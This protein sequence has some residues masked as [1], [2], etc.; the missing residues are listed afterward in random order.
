MASLVSLLLVAIVAQADSPRLEVQ[1]GHNAWIHG[2]AFS[3][4]G[5]L[6]ASASADES[7]RIWEVE[8]GRK[9]R[10]FYGH[11]KSVGDV[12]FHPRGKILVSI[13]LGDGVKLWDVDQGV[14]LVRW[15]DPSRGGWCLALN[16]AGTVI[17]REG[18]VGNLELLDFDTGKILRTLRGHQ[19]GIRSAA[20]DP[21]GTLLASGG[22]DGVLRVWDHDQGKELH[23]LRTQKAE[24]GIKTVAFSPDGLTLA[25]GDAGGNTHLWDTTTWQE[26]L[27]LHGGEAIAF[28]RDGRM[29]VG[30]A[31]TVVQIFDASDGRRLQLLRGHKEDINSVAVSPDDRWIASASDDRTVRIWERKSG[32]FV[33][34]LS[35]ESDLPYRAVFRRDGRAIAAGYSESIVALWDLASGR[36]ARVF[37]PRSTS[38]IDLAYSPD[39]KIV[40]VVDLLQQHLDLWDAETGQRLRNLGGRFNRFKAVAFRPD[41]RMMAASGR[42]DVGFTTDV[43][44]YD[45]ETGREIRIFRGHEVDVEA[46]AFRPDG[47]LLA[48][49]DGDGIVKLWDV[50]TGKEIRAVAGHRDDIRSIAFGPDGKTFFTTISDDSIIAWETDSGNRVHRFPMKGINCGALSPDGRVLAGGGDGAIT[51]WDVPGRRELHTYHVPGE[52]YS[53]SFPPDGATLLSAGLDGLIRLWNAR[54]PNFRE[55]ASLITFSDGTWAVTDPEGRFDASNGG[56]SSGL[57]WVVGREPIALN[58][59]KERYY[60]PGLLGK[61]SGFVKEPPRDVRGFRDVRLYPVVAFEPPAPSDTRMTLRLTDRGGGI[62]KV[63]VFVNDKELLADARGPRPDPEAHEARLAVDLAGAPV[64]R[65]APNRIRVVAWNA[66]GYLASR[67]LEAIWTPAGPSEA[68]TPELFAI[69]GGVSTYAAPALALRF[70]A[71]DADDFA[72]ALELGARRLLG[73]E[74]VHFT[75]LSTSD[76]PRAIVPTKDHF[77]EAFSAARRAR[78][79]DILLVYLAGHGVSLQRG[80]DL[81]CYLTQEARTTDSALLASD[82]S[83]LERYTVTSE[84]LV[85]WIKAIPALKQV[86]MLDTCAAGAAVARLTEL[87]EIS[88][89]QIR[90]MERLKDRTGFHILMGCASDRVSFEASQYGQGLLTYAL[91]Q[92][93]R[94]SALRDDEYVDV[95]RLFQF[96][97]DR[98]PELARGIGGV[99]KPLIAAPRG[100]SF[101]VGRLTLSDK[102]AI[103]LALARP[104]LLRPLL[105]NPDENDDNL[106]LAPMLKKRLNEAS[107][108]L[109]RGPM[110]RRAAIFVDADELPGAIRPT[111][112]YRVNG[113]KV[114]VHLLLKRDREKLGELDVEGTV[115]DTENLVE[116]TAAAIFDSLERNGR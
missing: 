24:A 74:R 40:A 51:L 112:S 34:V 9:L 89:D 2:I 46:L 71:K 13:G 49:G 110:D 21:R 3:P 39:G 88:G 64:I 98:V 86:M 19:G 7:I 116:K 41:G 20:F 92:G 23:A 10:T 90:A 15:H 50:E 68:D 44:L 97:A 59:L 87:R 48:T 75:L 100:T 84:E 108:S 95:S 61:V 43:G 14:E 67:G 106:G 54:W 76:D 93:M 83:L 29:L 78:P 62:G 77:R 47:R 12:A 6:L 52:I 60:D 38:L 109:A 25:S 32:R 81:Y 94:G 18:A 26:R 5:T 45:V 104:L 36:V 58:Q 114:R 31:G 28:S 66:E 42:E 115:A 70:A 102:K 8:T 99:Q 4:D 22:D 55:L 1:T 111:G 73:V 30:G 82:R 27:S 72:T 101:D 53:V 63:Q 91:L 11:L 69:V 79:R 96:A 113:T 65:G 107:F 103:T 105:F 17:A 33:R 37:N 35:G 57:H 56:S 85:E 80:S 16:P